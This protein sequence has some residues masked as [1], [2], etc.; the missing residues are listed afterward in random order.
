MKWRNISL[1]VLLV[2]LFYLYCHFEK[3]TFTWEPM[4]TNDIVRHTL[5]S[6]DHIMNHCPH[7]G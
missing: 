7:R 2:F 1:L 4:T 3:R 5:L 6:S